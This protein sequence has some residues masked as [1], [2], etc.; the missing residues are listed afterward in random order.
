[1]ITQPTTKE[2]S[3]ESLKNLIIH[4]GGQN[5]FINYVAQFNIKILSAYIKRI[6]K[7]EVLPPDIETFVKIYCYG[8][9]CLLC[10]IILT[11]KF[12]SADEL[13]KSMERALPEPLKKYLYKIDKV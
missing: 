5:S 1:M 13:V 12:D 8:T 9:V 4:T 11:G 6:E 10:E 7:I 3:A 2:L